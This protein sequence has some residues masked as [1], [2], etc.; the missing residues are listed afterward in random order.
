MLEIKTTEAIN[1]LFSFKYFFIF[2]N[3]D[4]YY[5][6][7]DYFRVLFKWPKTCKPSS[8]AGQPKLIHEVQGQTM[9][10]IW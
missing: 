2:T 3:C 4:Y 10:I 6:N 7:Y 1:I 5:N 8:R 9:T